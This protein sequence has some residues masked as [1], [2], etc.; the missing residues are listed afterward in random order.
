MEAGDA[1]QGLER[2]ES[3]LRK[4]ADEHGLTLTSD[5]PWPGFVP[6]EQQTGPVRHAIW[7]LSGRLPGGAVGRLRH[8][9]VYGEVIGMDVASQHTIMI[10]RLPE[11][12]GYL[13]MLCVRPKAIDSGLYYWGG[14][15]RPRE[16]QEFESTRMN[17]RYVVDIAKLQGQSW[18]FQLFAP[19]LID[20]IAHET[21]PDFG[22]MLDTGVF[23]CEVPQWRGQ[24]GSLSGEVDP[25]HLDLLASSGGEVA[26]RIR[27]E[28]LEEVGTGS[29]S[30]PDSAEAYAN[31]VAAPKHGRIVGTLLKLVGADKPDESV[32]R[33]AEENGMELESPAKFHARHITL[34]L[35]GAAEDV[36]TGALPGAQRQGSVA[37]IAFSSPV[38]MEQNYVAVTA[39]VDA[40]MDPVWIDAGEAAVPGY[41]DQLPAAVRQA[42]KEGGYGISSADGAACVYIRGPAPGSW[43][44]K[45][46]IEAFI[47]KGIEVLDALDG[48]GRQ[49]E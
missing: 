42:A 21:T 11:S 14:D 37:W 15:Q 4:Y 5:A 22:F 38:D 36:A 47:P 43:P 31:W 10:C 25:E 40:R 9:A 13:P 16:N 46:E 26:G 39:E 29:A 12:V 35:P 49:G 7:S 45:A 18:I 3:A 30:A 48:V 20:W 23:S 8:Q 19:S 17:R 28:V 44:R 2:S 1:I 41:G 24:P 27:D 33:W 34:P 32:A 6:A